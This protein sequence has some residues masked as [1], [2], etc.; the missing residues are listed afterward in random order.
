MYALAEVT[1]NSDF[2]T[3]ITA[4]KDQVLA[5]VNGAIPIALGVMAVVLGIRLGVKFFKS[6]VSK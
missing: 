5:N 2:I 3:A 6:I 1:A 4:A